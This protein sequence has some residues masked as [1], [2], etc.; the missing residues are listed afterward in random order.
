M[1]RAEGRVCQAGTRGAIRER[2]PGKLC[3]RVAGDK[4]GVALNGRVR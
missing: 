2:L 4:P 1:I 3:Y